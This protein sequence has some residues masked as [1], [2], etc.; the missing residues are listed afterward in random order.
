VVNQTW[1]GLADAVQAVRAELT[2]AAAQRGKNPLLFEVGSVELEFAVDFRH[3]T[4]VNAEVKA[5]VLSA[6]T[7]GQESK[8]S[9]QKVKVI[10]HPQK[11]GVAAKISGT[12]DFDP[13][14]MR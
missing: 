11:D 5:W 7:K 8:S 14:Q 13:E 4:G 3:E 2:S 1:V 10:L 6:E 12:V 9:G